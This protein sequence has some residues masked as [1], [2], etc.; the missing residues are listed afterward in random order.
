MSWR[1]LCLHDM[2][3]RKKPEATRFPPLEEFSLRRP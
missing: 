3:L 2:E 1:M